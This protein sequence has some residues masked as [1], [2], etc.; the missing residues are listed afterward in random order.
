MPDWVGNKYHGVNPESA[1]YS[2]AAHIP[3]MD[4]MAVENV[5]SRRENYK[6]VHTNAEKV[7]RTR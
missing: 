5:S 6:E 2:G 4:A 7:E 3:T 1:F